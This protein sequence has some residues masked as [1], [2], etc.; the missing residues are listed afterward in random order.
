MQALLERHK[1]YVSDLRL[2][3]LTYPSAGFVPMFSVGGPGAKSVRMHARSVTVQPPLES[4]ASAGE[5]LPKWDNEQGTLNRFL[6]A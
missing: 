6:H 3:L 1:T 5:A 2:K 4:S